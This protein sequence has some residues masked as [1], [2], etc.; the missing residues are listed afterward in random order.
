M[1]INPT[2][3]VNKETYNTPDF[4]DQRRIDPYKFSNTS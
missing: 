1:R 3:A 4:F 2:Q